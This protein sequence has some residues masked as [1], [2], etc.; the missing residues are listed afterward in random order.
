[1]GSVGYVTGFGRLRVLDD[2]TEPPEPHRIVEGLYCV[3]IDADI[4]APK[5]DNGG[6]LVVPEFVETAKSLGLNGQHG[7]PTF[8]ALAKHMLRGSGLEDKFRYEFASDRLHPKVHYLLGFEPTRE[9]VRL[10]EEGL[11]IPTLTKKRL[12]VARTVVDLAT[13]QEQIDFRYENSGLGEELQRFLQDLEKE[14]CSVA[15]Q[16]HQPY[17]VL[18][19]RDAEADTIQVVA[20]GSMLLS[21]DGSR[22]ATYELGDVVKIHSG[23]SFEGF[24]LGGGC[25]LFEA[26]LDRVQA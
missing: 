26:T 1:M 3:P 4:K 7:S 22:H 25:E 10:A 14:G 8:G 9:A 5:Y 23:S 2:Y 11:A 13:E 24:V 21:I 18:L 16:V 12:M 17:E 19:P 15:T 20:A 6:Y